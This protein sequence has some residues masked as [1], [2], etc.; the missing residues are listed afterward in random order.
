MYSHT[1]PPPFWDKSHTDCTMSWPRYL[2]ETRS[3]R[4]TGFSN[5]IGKPGLWHYVRLVI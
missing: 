5:K 3:D 1:R 4:S 2:A